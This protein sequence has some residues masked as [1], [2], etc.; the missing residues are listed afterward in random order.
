MLTVSRGRER[1]W[2]LAYVARVGRTAEGAQADAQ[3]RRTHTTEERPDT[4]GAEWRQSGAMRPKDPLK[5]RK[6]SENAKLGW[7]D[8]GG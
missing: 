8:S 3:R 5:R 4:S 2:R 1:K 7:A 6:S